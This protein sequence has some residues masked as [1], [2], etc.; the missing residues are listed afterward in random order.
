MTLMRKLLV[1]ALPLTLVAGCTQLSSEDRMALDNAVKSSQEAKTEAAQATA[2]ANRAS[3]SAE[4]AA[5]AARQAADAAN[6]AAAEA[7]AAGDKVDRAFRRGL[8]K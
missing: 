2:A 6:R 3:A 7:K 1:V 5:Q 4:S 8:R